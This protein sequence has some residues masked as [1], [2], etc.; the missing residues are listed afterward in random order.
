M[1]WRIA[2][3]NEFAVRRA[4]VPALSM[5]SE[6]LSRAWPYTSCAASV[7]ASATPLAFFLAS[8]RAR[9]KS[10]AFVEVWTMAFPLAVKVAGNVN[11]RVPVEFDDRELFSPMDFQTWASKARRLRGRA[12]CPAVFSD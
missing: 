9:L 2:F 10:V 1:V 8:S 3:S 5:T 12:D 11:A 7:T 4:A 6:A